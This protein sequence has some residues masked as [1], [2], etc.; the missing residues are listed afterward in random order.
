MIRKK[1]GKS[2]WLYLRQ[3]AA[4]MVVFGFISFPIS[5]NGHTYYVAKSGGEGRTQ[6]V[7]ILSC[8]IHDI[9]NASILVYH[10]DYVLIEDCD[11]WHCFCYATYARSAHTLD[12]AGGYIPTSSSHIT[13]RGNRIFENYLMTLKGARNY[14]CQRLLLIR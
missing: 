8:N 2:I 12:W 5:A 13:L 1:Y 7:D 14:S 10:S 9:R 3:L 11:I 6:H 4:S